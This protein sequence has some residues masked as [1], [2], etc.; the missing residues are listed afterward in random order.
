MPPNAR[1]FPDRALRA[2][3]L[4][5]ALFVA[6]DVHA[7]QVTA[8]GQDTAPGGTN[9]KEA[10]AAG[11]VVTFG[12]RSGGTTIR[13]TEPHGISRDT[14]LDGG[15]RIVLDGA[16]AM[17]MFNVSGGAVL[18]LRDVTVRGAVFNLSPLLGPPHR[19][20]VVSGLGTLRLVKVRTVG[21]VDPYDV[22]VIEVGG[23]SVFAGNSGDFVVA[24][25]RASITDARWQDN[26]GRALSVR[27]MAAHL[28]PPQATL[29]RVHLSGNQRP[30][31]WSGQ[32]QLRD[33]VFLRNGSPASLGGALHIRGG[34]ATIER[35]QFNDNQALVGGALL[36]DGGTVDLRR[37]DFTGNRAV[38]AGGAIATRSA[39]QAGAAPPVLRL[40]HAKLRTNQ[41]DRGGALAVEGPLDVGAVLFAGNQ[42]TRFGGALLAGAAPVQLSRVVFV[43]NRAGVS[44]GA[45][46][47]SREGQARLRG[48]NL[49]IARNESPRGGGLAGTVAQL[50]NATVVANKGGGLFAEPLHAGPPSRDAAIVLKNTLVAANEGGNCA[51]DLSVVH[52]E[53]HNLQFPRADCGADIPTAD[54]LLDSM[55]IPMIGSP[56]RL[57]AQATACLQDPLVKGYDAYG[58]NRMSGSACSIGAVEEDL[59][60]QAMR[61]LAPRRPDDLPPR[62]REF[63]RF[64]GVMR[65]QSPP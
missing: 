46:S 23:D 31:S 45:I 57:A 25:H 59:Q 5:F 52:D 60:R 11:G 4:G 3:L 35:V 47:A 9:L 56:A 28:G 13:I 22:A 24:A 41:A 26:T 37:S 36:V 63:M 19:G 20:S 38:E 53:G 55:F 54:P 44:G 64:I 61:L 1:S 16:G 39:G 32:L 50:T 30:L 42:A 65:T 12:C 51:G 62:V 8:C 21:N 17:R 7:V 2:G 14:Q 18:T 29:Q 49:L 10:L 43:D 6:A 15:G 40:S 48:G 33:A 27:T 58:G 34:R